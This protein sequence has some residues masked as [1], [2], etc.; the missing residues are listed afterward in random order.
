VF[1]VT[2]AAIP[3]RAVSDGDELVAPT[4]DLL[5]G[6]NLLGTDKDNEGADGVTS[7]IS[8]PPQSVALIEAGA[9]AAAKWWA[10]GLG[11]AALG[12]WTA[13]G[14]WWPEQRIE[15][16][17]ATIAAAAI[18]TATLVL[19]IGHL[20]ASDVRGRAAAAVSVNEA[21][22]SVARVMLE[23]ARDVH[24]PSETTPATEIVPLPDQIRVKYSARP[25]DDEDGWLAIAISH[26]GGEGIKYVVVKGSSQAVVPASE[27]KFG[28]RERGR[29][30]R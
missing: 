3:S 12:A 19:A 25:D 21:R 5:I 6:L 27:L 14:I 16:Q 18:V 30:Q 2:S 23:A 8:G 11:T 28:A 26:Q 29:L 13:V 10:G 1:S 24:R 22:A 20:I 7:V 17:V 4:K 15:I 9:T